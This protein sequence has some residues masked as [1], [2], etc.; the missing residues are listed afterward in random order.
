MR[1]GSA[2]S[3]SRRDGSAGRAM[4]SS[5]KVEAR[6]EPFAFDPAR[7]AVIVVD[8]QNGFVSRKGYL[9]RAGFDVGQ[10]QTT[11]ANCQQLLA[12]TRAAGIRTIY[13]QMGWHEDL[14]DAGSADGGMYHKSVALRFMRKQRQNDRTALIRGTWDYA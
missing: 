8:M 14:H 7:A 10:A 3:D 12:A 13:L 2:P 4:F 5:V 1:R 11:L 6:P 9:A